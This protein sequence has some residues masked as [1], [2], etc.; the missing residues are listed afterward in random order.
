MF[1]LLSIY[2]LTYFPK[3]EKDHV[4][5]KARFP[6]FPVLGQISTTNFLKS[7]SHHFRAKILIILGDDEETI[8]P[9]S[10]LL[11]E[12]GVPPLQVTCRGEDSSSGSNTPPACIGP[13]KAPRFTRIL[14]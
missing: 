13:S 7:A 6:A 9:A 5:D 1:N 3:C 4:R 10:Q 11:P 12:G 14:T 8:Y 2:P